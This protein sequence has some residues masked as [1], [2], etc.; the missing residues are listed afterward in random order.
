MTPQQKLRQLY[1]RAQRIHEKYPPGTGNYDR[2]RGD[3]IRL[4]KAWG[5]MV[6]VCQSQGWDFEDAIIALAADRPLPGEE[7]A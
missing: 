7:V 4:G 1:S 6:R 2:N 3:N 5:A